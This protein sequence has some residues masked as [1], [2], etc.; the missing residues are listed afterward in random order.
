V[1]EHTDVAGAIISRSAKIADSHVFNTSLKFQTGPTTNVLRHDV[2]TK[3][4]LKEFQLSQ[5]SKRLAF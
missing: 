1:L 2:M 4:N 5:V 3:L